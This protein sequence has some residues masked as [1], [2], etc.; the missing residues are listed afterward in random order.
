MMDSA[1]EAPLGV[2]GRHS[3][4]PLQLSRGIHKELRWLLMGHEVASEQ[5]TLPGIF[6][7]CQLLSSLLKFRFQQ[8]TVVFLLSSSYHVLIFLI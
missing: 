3:C 5:S 6:A 4:E 1:E 8:A 2:S 7:P